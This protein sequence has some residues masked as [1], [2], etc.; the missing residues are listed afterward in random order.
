VQCPRCGRDNPLDPLYCDQCGA[1]VEVVCPACRALNRPSAKFCRTCGQYLVAGTA[2][3][4]APR[5]AAPESYT[6]SHLAERILTSRAALEGERKQV[7]VLFA[8]LKGSMELLADRDPEEAR[9]IL[10]PVLQHM[11]DAVHRFEGT[12]NQVM[13]DGIMALFGAPLAHEDHALRAC[14]AA[15]DMQER[16]KRYAE[17]VRRSDAAVVKIRVG[18][19]SGEVVVRAIGSDLRM[20]YTAVGQTT[21]LA[22]RMEQLA[23][24]GTIVIAPDTQALVEGHVDVRPLGPVRVRGLAAA[25]EVYELTGAG[26]V[27]TRLQATVARRGLTRFVGR[28]AELGHLRRTQELAGN[29]AGQVVAIVGDAGVGKSRLVY[30][31]ARSL[32]TQDRLVLESAAVSYGKATSHLAVI[33]LL[34]R[35]FRIEPRDDSCQIREKV[36]G[37][38][39]TLDWTL[40]PTLPAMLTLLDAHGDDALWR[41]LEPT[42]RRQRTLDALTRWVLRVAREQPLLLIVEDLHW[43]DAETQALLDCLVDS[44]GSARVLLVVTYRP[45]FPHGWAGKAHYTEIRVDVLGPAEA[46]ELLQA[47]LGAGSGLDDLKRLLVQRTEGNPLFLEESVRT[48]AETKALAGASG[49]YHIAQPISAIRIAPSLH[50]LL[51]ARIDRLSSDEKR[52]LQA[53]AV[54]GTDVPVVLLQQIADAPD[55]D[56]RRGLAALQAA[57]FLHE[58]NLFPELEYAFAHALTHEVAYGTLLQP[59]RREL[60]ARIVDALERLRADRLG[61][62]WDKATLYLRQAG[63]KAAGRSGYAEA[64]GHFEDALGAL[65]REIGDRRRLG[66]VMAD[67]GARLRNLG[68]HARALEATRQALDIARELEDADLAIEATY[69]LAQAHFAVGDL[70]EAGVL[71]QEVAQSHTDNRPA[72]TLP[73][74]FAAWPRAWLAL[75]L[76]QL[77]RFTEAT[78]HAE[79]AI[80][81]AELAAHPHTVVESHAALGGVTLERGDLGTARRTFEHVVTLLQARNARDANVL[82][83]LGYAYVLSGRLS[84]GLP[85]LKESVRGEVWM[86]SRVSVSPCTSPAW[87][88]PIPL[89]AGPVRRW[90]TPEPQLICHGSTR[91]ERTRPR[92]SECWLTSLPAATLSIRRLQETPMRRASPWLRRSACARSWRTVTAG[93]PSSAVGQANGSRPRSSSESR[94]RGIASWA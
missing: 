11:M 55:A 36:T 28:N 86:S 21:H 54:I 38:L 93:S 83:G 10:D 94:R 84:E 18:L 43:I 70:V 46:E 33:D 26:R 49:A 81:I 14:Y 13:G 31:F 40:E 64:R 78:V 90:S 29:G 44:V 59:Q 35:Y 82:S 69:R 76:A 27:R 85:L 15:L 66:L 30:E 1:R 24:P 87:L 58:A 74:F 72:S 42:E 48:L 19:N 22:A 80:R 88:R 50:A 12:V 77:G 41:S 32:R 89:R 4:D 34:K 45:V 9:T 20:D 2:S 37:K 68:E 52:L 56:V 79:D 6:P 62:L 60:H 67:I 3:G 63:I 65:A 39:L 23:E 25:V 17:A 57:G 5:V 91:S 71:F 92:R 75:T 8:D 47:L 73:P 7:T 61:E 51:A 53:A 16:V